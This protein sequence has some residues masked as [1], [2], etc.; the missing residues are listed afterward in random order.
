MQIVRGRFLVTAA[1]AVSRLIIT[2]YDLY[3]QRIC[4]QVKVPVVQD[5]S[6]QPQA[7][8]GLFQDDRISSIGCE[9]HH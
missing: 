5:P 1:N 3:R 8:P 6:S 2:V 9:L 4:H 7:G